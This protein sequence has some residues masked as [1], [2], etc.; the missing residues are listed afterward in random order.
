MAPGPAAID[1]HHP[2][3]SSAP[4]CFPF[5]ARPLGP[6]PRPRGDAGRQPPPPAPNR[7]APWEST[8]SPLWLSRS[9]AESPALIRRC[10]CFDRGRGASDRRSARSALMPARLRRG[11]AA[12]QTAAGGARPAPRQA[13]AGGLASGL[14]L[15]LANHTGGAARATLPA[16]LSGRTVTAAAWLSA[17]QSHALAALFR[18]GGRQQATLSLC[19]TWPGRQLPAAHGVLLAG[20]LHCIPRHSWPAGPA[21]VGGRRSRCNGCAISGVCRV[22][23]KAQRG[24]K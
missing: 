1:L 9:S 6:A 14:R 3:D 21:R 10:R 11:A 20:R 7:F 12:P 15:R 24:E 23:E 5:L 13:P 8:Q 17:R 2:P 16:R 18:I 4:R 22:S 19:A